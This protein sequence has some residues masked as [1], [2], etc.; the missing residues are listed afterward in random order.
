MA[1]SPLERKKVVYISIRPP[2]AGSILVWGRV[3]GMMACLSY[4]SRPWASAMVARSPL[5]L[6]L[7]FRV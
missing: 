3:G 7:R 4:F 2:F 6:D 5:G 1:H